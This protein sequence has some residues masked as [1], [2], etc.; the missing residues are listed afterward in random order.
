MRCFLLSASISF[1]IAAVAGPPAEP[2]E[3]TTPSG[4]VMVLLPGGTFT[5]GDNDGEV[6]EPE[7]AVTVSPFCIDQFEVSQEE[8]ERLMGD[9]PSK[10]KSKKNPVEQI[11]WSD[12]VRY[13][14]ARSREEGLEPAYDLTAWTC[15]F[16]A[17]GYRLPT[18]AEWEYAA[19]AGT[20]TAY[21]FG[22][23]DDD[24]T[25]HAWFKDNA[26]AK[27]HPVRQRRPNPWGLYDMH[28]NVWEWCNDFY[29]VDYYL[30][31]EAEDPRGPERGAKKVLR[32]G[33]WNSTPDACRSAYRYNEN[34]AY[35]DA[36]FGYDIYGFRCVR[37]WSEK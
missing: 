7:H 32:G 2:S 12:A 27:P 25:K 26:K 16:E 23:S 19:R 29:Q 6:D 10:V 35:T 37:P 31:S 28:G 5:M 30:R 9:N 1:A 17:N 3:I 8:Y 24:L 20:G 15:N 33:C 14:N 4:A 18:E 34:P 11:R 36:C 22:A 21:S 13:C